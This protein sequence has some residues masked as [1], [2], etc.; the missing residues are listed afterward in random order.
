MN[1]VFRLLENKEI[2]VA[3]SVKKGL[4]YGFIIISILFFGWYL[5][6]LYY[7]FWG[8]VGDVETPVITNVS[9]EDANKILKS[10]RLR[11]LVVDSRYDNTVPENTV[12]T[13]EPLPGVRVKRGRDILV[14]VSSGPDL[15]DVPKVTGLTLRE[16]KIMLANYKLEV[17]KIENGQDNSVE[18]EQIFRQDPLAGSKVKK[19]SKVDVVVNSGGHPDIKVDKYIGSNISD[20]RSKLEA[21]R[22]KIGEIKW[23]YSDEKDLGEIL[24]QSLEEGRLVYP[25]TNISF[26]ISAGTR[27]IDLKLKQDNIVFV[28]PASSKRMNVKVEINDLTGVQTVYEGLHSSGDRLTLF[29]TSW[30]PSEVIVYIDEKIVKR[31]NL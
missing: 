7:T 26:K 19:G 28:V 10:K 30:G 8:S 3:E 20:V 24:W 22:L 18:Q 4:L 5:F 9:L 25:G 14:V 29:V 6:N 31:A 16:A 27:Y 17:G 21:T 23:E 15:S 13:Q 1:S 12:I 2:I 11:I